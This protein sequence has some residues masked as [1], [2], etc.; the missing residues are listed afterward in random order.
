MYSIF[1]ISILLNLF[2]LKCNNIGAIINKSLNLMR[3]LKLFKLY[4][5]QMITY[6][7]KYFVKTIIIINI[8]VFFSKMV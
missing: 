6:F 8:I 7:L 4:L 1:L 5:F 2:L 3:R